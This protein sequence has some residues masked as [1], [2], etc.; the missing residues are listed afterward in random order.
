MTQAGPG[1]APQSMQRTCRVF[2]A[3]PR[4]VAA[5][6]A[7]LAGVLAGCPVLHDA[8]LCLSDLA[9]CERMLLV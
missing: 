6:R 2:P 7:F 5:A 4:Q 3:Q 9:T 1:A 8:V